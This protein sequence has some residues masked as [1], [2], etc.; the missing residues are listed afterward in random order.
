MKANEAP[1]KLYVD[2]NDNLSDSF[3]YGFTEKRKEDDI[4]YTHTDTFI[5]KAC[6]FISK[7]IESDKYVSPDE[8]SYRLGFPYNYFETSMFINDFKEYMKKESL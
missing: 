2:V 5:E 7:Y 3:L 8:E 1:E 4:E 6:E